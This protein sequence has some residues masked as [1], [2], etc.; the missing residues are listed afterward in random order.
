MN[1]MCHLIDV[2][3]SKRARWNWLK[4]HV[5][6]VLVDRRS[7]NFVMVSIYSFGQDYEIG[8]GAALHLWSLPYCLLLL[9]DTGSKRSL[10]RI[11]KHNLYI[12]QER[13]R[14]STIKV[15]CVDRVPQI[16]TSLKHTICYKGTI[17][18]YLI[19]RYYIQYMVYIL[20][21]W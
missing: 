15:L 7:G 11:W 1:Y 5:L 4:L 3:I 19:L 12:N 21:V 6:D 18:Y 9:N 10:D 16:R 20:Y 2:C 13:G 17:W 8:R 14:L